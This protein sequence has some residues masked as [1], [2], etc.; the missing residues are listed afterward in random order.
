LFNVTYILQYNP[1]IAS[2]AKLTLEVEGFQSAD[3][4]AVLELLPSQKRKEP[5]ARVFAKIGFEAE[6]KTKK[7]KEK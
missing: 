1:Q 6:N 3:E 4:G 7:K 2:P 5:K